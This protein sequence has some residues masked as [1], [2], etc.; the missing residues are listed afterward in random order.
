MKLYSLHRCGSD[1][2][3]IAEIVC[4]VGSREQAEQAIHQM[5]L[6]TVRIH[7]MSGPHTKTCRSI[8]EL[9]DSETGWWL[10]VNMFRIGVCTAHHRDGLPAFFLTK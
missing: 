5:F 3:T 4:D 10:Q 2:F 9:V 7:E 8:A 6:G 1:K